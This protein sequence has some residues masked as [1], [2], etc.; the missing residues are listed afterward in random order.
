MGAVETKVKEALDYNYQT[1]EVEKEQ[2]E[3][4]NETDDEIED[5]E[6]TSQDATVPMEEELVDDQNTS[7]VLSTTTEGKADDGEEEPGN[8]QQSWE[9]FELA[10][11]IYKR[12][13][14]TEAA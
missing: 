2:M 1:C 14:E 12:E 4:E 7:K 8:L 6:K 11:L 10:K 3:A 13:V 9:M 5:E